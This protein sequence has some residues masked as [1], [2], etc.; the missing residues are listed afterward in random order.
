MF[1]GISNGYAGEGTGAVAPWLG[2]ELRH[3]WRAAH[4]EAVCAYR[5]WHA[6]GGEETY[7]V[8]RAA[9]DRADVAQDALALTAGVGAAER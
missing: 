2:E 4:E 8:Y 5:A 3:A 6:T 1:S 9:Q 7:A